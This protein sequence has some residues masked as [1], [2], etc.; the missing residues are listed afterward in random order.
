M[1]TNSYATIHSWLQEASQRLASSGIMTNRLDSLILLE[2]T[3]GKDRAWILAN[4]DEELSIFMLKE[5]NKKIAR[6]MTHEPLAYI[7]GHTEFYGNEFLVNKHVLEPRP[8]S[9]TI[10]DL[11]VELMNTSIKNPAVID[12]G[13]GSGALA[14]T[15]KLKWPNIPVVAIDVD[16]RCLKVAEQNAKKLNVK[17]NLLEGYL[18]EPLESLFKDQARTFI[19]LC[20]LP[21]VPN[22]FQINPAAMREPRIAIF[23]GPDGLSLYNE[24]FGTLSLVKSNYPLTIITESLPTQHVRLE[25][26]ARSSGFKKIGTKDFIQV[27]VSNQN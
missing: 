12:V 22:N 15:A 6:R 9:E 27:F 8:E 18:L 17:I 26:I 16:R 5:L 11:L 21:Y 25:E 10:I 20:N 2:D 4:E 24:L 7:R 23:G 14:I 1:S 19:F 3:I 13:T